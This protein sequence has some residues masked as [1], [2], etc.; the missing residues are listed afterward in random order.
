MKTKNTSTKLNYF[1][2]AIASRK[3]IDILLLLSEK[4]NLSLKEI[5]KSINTIQ[6]NTSLH[7]F[8]LLNN[9]ILMK[10]QKG[11]EVEHKLTNKGKKIVSFIRNIDK[12][13]SG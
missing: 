6:Q 7:V 12:D 11:I 13:I 1:F 10:R 9:G 5:S 8:K 4:E 2:S 3:R